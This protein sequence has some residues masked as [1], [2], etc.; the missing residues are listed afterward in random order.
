MLT[1]L[2]FYTSLFAA[3]KT[4]SQAVIDPAGVVQSQVI[5]S[6]IR[7]GEG[8][9]L[10]LVLNGSQSQQTLSARFLTDFFGSGMQHIAFASADIVKTVKQLM[11][12]GVDMLPIPGNYYDDLE[13]RADLTP[14][15]I[16]AFK[17]LNILYDKDAGGAF[18]QAYTTTLEGGFFF[19]IVQ[20]D[21]YQGYGAAN[22]GIRLTAQ[23]RMAR[24]RSMPTY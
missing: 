23:A 16:D 21:G 8:Q 3:E 5:E 20:R 9:G 1:W 17:A 14:E 4:A 18:L 2:L 11:A 12:N 24:P 10:R 22:A 7:E 6:G 19:E 13:A 15:M